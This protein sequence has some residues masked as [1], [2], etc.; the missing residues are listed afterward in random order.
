MR[1]VLLCFL[2]MPFFADAQENF[3][4]LARG[5]SIFTED[6][7]YRTEI[8]KETGF[9]TD[10]GFFCTNEIAAIKNQNGYFINVSDLKKGEEHWAFRFQKT[11]ISLFEEVDM[12]VYGTTLPGFNKSRKPQKGMASG[13][14]IDFYSNE[15]GIAKRVNY[16]N[17]RLDL[18]S[19][20]ESLGHLKRSRT[21]QWCQVGLQLSGAG[22]FTSGFVGLGETAFRFTPA[23]LLGVL[24]GGGSF[25]LVEP[26]RDAR[27]MA[28]D[29]YNKSATSL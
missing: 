16:S 7:T 29:V 27:W 8:L 19:N 21:Y 24:M 22:L 17:L 11:P 5:E 1:A 28:I 6:I 20:A 18:S 4:L 12:N 2:F 15:E 13:Q 10:V 9:K 23:M 25:L 14:R 26:I 3:V